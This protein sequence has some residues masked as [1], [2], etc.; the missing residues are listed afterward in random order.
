MDT[1]RL[2][3]LSCFI[4]PLAPRWAWAS[5]ERPYAGRFG[6]APAACLSNGKRHRQM[7]PPRVATEAAQTATIRARAAHR[8]RL[9]G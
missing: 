7:Q 2:M 4:V 1:G 5:S 8:M 9:R 6:K 3:S